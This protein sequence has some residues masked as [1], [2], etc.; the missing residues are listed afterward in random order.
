MVE[1]SA[2]DWWDWPPTVSTLQGSSLSCRRNTA[3]RNSNPLQ[4]V[5]VWVAS[6]LLCP[7]FPQFLALSLFF[8]FFLPESDVF[9]VCIFS[10]HMW[11]RVLKMRK[12]ELKTHV[13]IQRGMP[14]WQGRFGHGQRTVSKYMTRR[15]LRLRG[16]PEAQMRAKSRFIDVVCVCERERRVRWR[17][18]IG[19]CQ[20]TRRFFC[21]LS[22]DK[23]M[24]NQSQM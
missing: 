24:T 18:V 23:G 9:Y 7:W 21:I 14:D 16:R 15:I 22:T 12:K 20:H 3:R 5:K 13:D 1:P 10:L 17:R 11:R 4:G 6:V 8:S 2:N 19:C